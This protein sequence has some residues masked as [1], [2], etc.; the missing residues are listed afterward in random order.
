MRHTEISGR[1]D[2]GHDAVGPPVLLVDDAVVAARE[3]A[4]R[5]LAELLGVHG[6]GRLQV[7]QSL[8]REVAL[9]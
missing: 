1:D 4:L 6:V 8:S 7:G 3:V 9:E 5:E 2:V